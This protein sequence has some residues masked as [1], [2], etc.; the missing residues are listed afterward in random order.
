MNLINMIEVIKIE[1]KFNWKMVLGVF[2]S[3]V[4]IGLGV[5]MIVANEGVI[6]SMQRGIGG[7]LILNALT[8]LWYIIRMALIMLHRK[9]TTEK[10]KNLID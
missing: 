4:M 7:L 1:K 2:I 9:I 6:K 8:D 10:G 5:T 3:I